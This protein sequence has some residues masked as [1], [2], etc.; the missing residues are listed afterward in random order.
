MKAKTKIDISMKTKKKKPIK[1]WILLV[2]KCGDILPILPL[3]G[4]FG[5]LV[6]GAAGVAKVIND[7]KAAQR[8]LEEL[9]R[10]ITEGHGVYLAPYKHGWEVTTEKIKKIKKNAKQLSK[11]PKDVTKIQL[12]QLTK[13]MRI[14]YFRNIFMRTTLPTEKV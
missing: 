9:K 10:H 12:Q 13:R 7:N 6:S 2:V 4:V 8:Q 1:E 3:L 5:S 14:P 11:L